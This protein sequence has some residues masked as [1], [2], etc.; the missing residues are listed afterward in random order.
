[1]PGNRC[2]NVENDVN[3]KAFL[4]LIRYAEHKREDDS[5]YYMLY[6]GQRIFTDMSKHPDQSIKAWGKTSTAAGAYQILTETYTLLKKQGITDFMPESQD[7]MAILLIT[8]R[9]ALRFVIDGKIEEAIPYLLRE[10]PSLPGGSQSK[11][12]ITEARQRFDRY[13]AEYKQ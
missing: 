12:T 2:I 4:K 1:M 8:R 5:V 9:G 6:G 13:V 11:M 7:R 3:V 10:W